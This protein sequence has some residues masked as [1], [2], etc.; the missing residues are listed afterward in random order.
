MSFGSSIISFSN[1][2]EKFINNIGRYGIDFEDYLF[3][4]C[5]WFFCFGF[6]M[7]LNFIFIIVVGKKC[8]VFDFEEEV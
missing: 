3:V 1:S 7:F 8:K 6:L 4:Y 5:N 2:S